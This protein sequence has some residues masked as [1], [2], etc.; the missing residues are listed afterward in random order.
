MSRYLTI[1]AGVA[2]AALAMAA[3]AAAAPP[4][5]DTFAGATTISSLPFSDTVDT[6]QAT[7]DADDI[8]AAACGGTHV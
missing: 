1:L 5:N 3:P 2:I 8:V 7:T 4:S 6:T